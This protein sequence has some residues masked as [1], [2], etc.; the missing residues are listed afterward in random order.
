MEHIKPHEYELPDGTKFSIG[1]ERCLFPEAFFCGVDVVNDELKKQNNMEVDAEEEAANLKGFIGMQHLVT[2]SIN[3]A[4]LDI[5]K[6]L[7]GNIL[8]TGG[9]SMTTG[10][11]SRLQKEV[12]EIAPQN[13]RVK[14]FSS[15][16]G[17][18]TES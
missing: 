16:S 13:L 7:Y 9:N 2:E 4:D 12:P 10:F 11:M 8:V 3:Q 1:G 15:H 5:R 6:E 17:A 14:V 18:V